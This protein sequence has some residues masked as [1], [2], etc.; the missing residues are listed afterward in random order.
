MRL[1]ELKGI[2]PAAKRLILEVEK[3]GEAD[4]ITLNIYPYTVQ[5][6]IEIENMDKELKKKKAGT[7]EYEDYSKYITENIVYIILKKTIEDISLSD[8]KTNIPPIWYEPIIQKCLEFEGVT[9]EKF[10]EFK[11]KQLDSQLE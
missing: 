2:S 7:K 3:D 5:D 6:K 10:E 11:K 9:Q 4:S 8:I 1:D